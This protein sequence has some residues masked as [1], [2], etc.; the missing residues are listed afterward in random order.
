MGNQ[1]LDINNPDQKYRLKSLPGQFSG[2]HLLSIMYS[3]FRQIDPSMDLG[4]DFESEYKA[5]IELKKVEGPADFGA[6]SRRAARSRLSIRSDVPLGR[7]W[8]QIRLKSRTLRSLLDRWL[9]VRRAPLRCTRLPRLY[10]GHLFDEPRDMP[11]QLP[12]CRFARLGQC[13]A[14]LHPGINSRLPRRMVL[15]SVLFG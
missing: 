4:M 2:L 3:A 11:S 14:D 13:Q 9:R 6:L 7:L 8:L 5:A 10:G 1:G 15:R 12:V